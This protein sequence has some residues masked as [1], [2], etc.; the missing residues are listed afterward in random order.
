VGNLLLLGLQ[1]LVAALLE[2]VA[3]VAQTQQ[4]GQQQGTADE[5][6]ALGL[7]GFPVLS[8]QVDVLL[9]ELKGL[10]LLAG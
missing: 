6:V 8:Q 2:A 4:G 10:F 7:L 9:A 5:G 3:V 1:Q